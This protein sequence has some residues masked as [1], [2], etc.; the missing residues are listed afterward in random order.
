MLVFD[1][2][3]FNSYKVVTEAGSVDANATIQ[4]AFT[5][6]SS[7]R[8]EQFF[9]SISVITDKVPKDAQSVVEFH[10]PNTQ[11]TEIPVLFTFFLAVFNHSPLIY[12]HLDSSNSIYAEVCLFTLLKISLIKVINLIY[13][14]WIINNSMN[15]VIGYLSTLKTNTSLHRKQF[16][17]FSANI[18]VYSLS[19]FYKL[20]KLLPFSSFFI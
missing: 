10:N 18:N 17:F 8:T 3:N 7:N 13:S 1:K 12:Q 4:S 14:Y 19:F 2:H 15:Y 9:Q 5:Q 11:Q 20:E 16:L 6:S